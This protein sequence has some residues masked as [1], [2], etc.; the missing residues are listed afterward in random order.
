M[1]CVEQI[2]AA[3]EKLGTVPARRAQ[4]SVPAVRRRPP[5]KCVL[6]KVSYKSPRIVVGVDEVVVVAVVVGFVA[7]VVSLSLLLMLLLVLLSVLV[8]VWLLYYFTN[9][10]SGQAVLIAVS[11]PPP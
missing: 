11:P 9:R 8:L 5:E 7:G 6:L 4:G 10:P 3:Q 2:E 1:R